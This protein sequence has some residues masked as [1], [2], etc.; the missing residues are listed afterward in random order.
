MDRSWRPVWSAGWLFYGVENDVFIYIYAL[1][2]F[3]DW[4]LF[5]VYSLVKTC[6]FVICGCGICDFE[7]SQHYFFRRNVKQKMFPVYCW[8][9]D[10]F[11]ITF[12]FKKI[13]LLDFNT[14]FQV[15]NT[16]NNCCSSILERKRTSQKKIENLFCRLPKNN[17]YFFYFF[18]QDP[19]DAANKESRK[20]SSA[21]ASAAADYLHHRSYHLHGGLLTPTTTSSTISQRSERSERGRTAAGENDSNIRSRTLRR[22][23]TQGGT[24]ESSRDSID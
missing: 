4:W 10:G 6:I 21:A 22:E 23:S 19:N 7:L 5:S 11:A 13:C 9:C 18:N 20:D 12:H 16:Y 2:N 3:D 17:L 24:D 8:S 15:K 1:M 14:V